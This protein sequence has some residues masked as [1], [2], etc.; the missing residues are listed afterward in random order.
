MNPELRAKYEVVIGI[1]CHT[2]LVTKTKLFC[3]CDNDSRDADPNTHVCPVCFGLPGTL[4]V[5]NKHAVELGLRLGNALNATYPEDYHTK[6]DRK[7]YY[8][9]DL[10][11]GYQITQFDE[12]IVGPGYVEFPLDGQTRRIGITRA[13]LEGDAGKL[14]HPEGAD[15]SLVDLN[16]A[17]TPLL[18]IVSEPD[19]RSAAEAKAYAQ[20]LHNIVRYAGVSDA[21][22]YY[23]NMRFDVNVSVRLVGAPEFGTRTETKNLNSFK[24]IERAVEYEVKRQIVLVE[25]GGK[26]RQET[27]GWNDAKQETYAM[28][29]K[30]DADE[31]RYFPEPD[32]PPLVITRDMVEAQRNELGLLPNDLRREL[33]AAKMPPKES[34]VLVA[35]PTAARLWHQVISENPE[36]AK[37]AFN[38]LIGDAVT[39]AADRSL[40]N[41]EITTGVLVEVG[42]MVKDGRLSS[43]NA[44]LLLSK[45]WHEASDPKKIAQNLNLLQESNEDELGAVVDE[46]IA[47]NAQAVADY[48]AGNQRAFG[49]LVGQSMKKTQGKGNPPLINKLL[50]DRLG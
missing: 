32:L 12:P 4:P 18:E 9:P 23:G 10:P 14:T 17:E 21:N 8:Y 1:E 13:H 43:T 48:K 42:R 20:E 25:E 15:Y 35:D 5:L 27:R 49:A 36:Q 7:N 33:A 38:W 44:K 45:L 39:L 37:F 6:F 29:S 11:K 24:A 19:M 26:V 46:V 47:E 41:S 30:E 28:R 16:R 40:E 31:Y 3:G 22:L 34:E 2:Q 50:K